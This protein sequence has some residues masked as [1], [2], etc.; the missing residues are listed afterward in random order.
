MTADPIP[1]NDADADDDGGELASADWTRVAAP[2]SDLPAALAGTDR[3]TEILRALRKVE[4]ASSAHAEWLRDWHLYVLG[5]LEPGA[6]P[7]AAPPAFDFGGRFEALRASIPGKDAEFAE[8]GKRLKRTKRQAERIIRTVEM[9]RKLP[10]ADYE[11]LMR[12]V[13][14]LD[15]L[16]R[17]LQN[18]SWNHLANIDPLTGLGNRQAMARKLAVERERQARNRQP[19]CVA[20]IDLDFF[21]EIND[22][23]GHK[24]GDTVLRSLASL[25]AVSIRPYDEVFRY[26]GDEFVVCLPNAD[27]RAA[28]A[29]VER[30]RLRV[31]RWS[32]PLRGDDR[33]RMTV[34]VGVAPLDHDR[35]VEAALEAA[36]A[37]L[38]AAK[39]NGRNCVHVRSME[40]R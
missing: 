18:D 33:V 6:A 31:A 27:T 39:R 32:I 16:L 28:W 23:H 25:L 35:D 21:K 2:S 8:I 40:E 37:A 12:A 5:C 34:S 36:D 1:T 20:L 7:R 4:E 30:L 10:P 3:P 9:D 26:G 22:T 24:A 19:C 29:I 15:G 17:Q 14:E 11:G 38:Y 13:H